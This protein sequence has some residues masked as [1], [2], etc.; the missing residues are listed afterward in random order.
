MAGAQQ[1]LPFPRT[2]VR[3]IFRRNLCIECLVQTERIHIAMIDSCQ[4]NVGLVERLLGRIALGDSLLLQTI[5]FL[6]S[7]FRNRTLLIGDCTLRIGCPAIAL[8][9]GQRP[10]GDNGITGAQNRGGNHHEQQRG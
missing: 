1:I 7:R 3:S 6:L 5:G 9:I 4:P 8:G 10:I 2:Q